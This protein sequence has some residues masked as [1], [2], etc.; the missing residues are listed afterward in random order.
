MTSFSEP[1]APEY[2]ALIS[3]PPVAT[4]ETRPC[5]FTVATT[6][7]ADCHVASDVTFAVDPSARVE[8][9]VNCE[10]D[11]ITGVLPVTVMDWTAGL[12]G[13]E[14]VDADSPQAH[15][16]VSRTITAARRSVLT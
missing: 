6:G 12:D 8:V 16:I 5:A 13:A 4:A 1:T 11:P 7:L 3:T 2:A 14:A 10:V 15:N 9:A